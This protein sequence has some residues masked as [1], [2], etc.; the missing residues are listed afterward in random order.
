[1]TLAGLLSHVVEQFEAAA[2]EY[3]IGGSVASSIYGE[4]R[5]TRDVDIVVAGDDATLR[6]LFQRF[7]RERVYIDE[8]ADDQPIRAGQMVCLLDLHSGWKADLIVR[9]N[10]P[11]S[12]AEF[13]RRQRMD[14]LGV[15]AWVAS[16][17]DVILTKLEWAARSGSSQ[18]IDDVRGIVAVQ[19]DT[20]DVDHLRRW[21]RP[22]QVGEL[23]ESCLSPT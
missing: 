5:T 6:E 10:R 11:F 7:D 17:E 1:M 13:S 23:L 3:M 12:V 15:A 19:G 4:P 16:V 18:Q 22:L 2:V 21:A 20:L 14:V 8:P 9:S